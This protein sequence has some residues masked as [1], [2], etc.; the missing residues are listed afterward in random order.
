MSWWNLYEMG[1][2]S[3][4]SLQHPSGFLQNQWSNHVDDIMPGDDSHNV[5]ILPAPIHFEITF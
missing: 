5:Y 3:L 4:S 1:P 2:Q